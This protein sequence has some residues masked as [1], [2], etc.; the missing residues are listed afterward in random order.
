MKKPFAVKI[1]MPNGDA[2]ALKIIHKGN[3]TGLGLEISRTAWPEHRDRTEL[4]QA[5]IYIL[6]GYIDSDNLPYLYIGHGSDIEKR[7]EKHFNDTSFWD[8]VLIFVSRDDSLNR[9]H[10]TWLVWALIKQ[11]HIVNRCKLNN[12]K[13]P[14]KPRLTISEQ[15]STHEFLNEILSI[16][17]LLEV[18]AFEAPK[19]I[20]QLDISPSDLEIDDTIIIPAPV[21]GFRNYFLDSGYCCAIR[22]AGGKLNQ[23]KYI[24]AYQTAPISAITHVAEIDSIEP[25]GDGKKYRV[26]FASICK[27]DGIFKVGNRSRVDML[28][29]RYANYRILAG[30]SDMDE[31]FES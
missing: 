13:S 28:N 24:A 16:L 1:F 19:S 22:I 21:K 5:G 2:G 26:N 12:E 23:L 31:L 27:T 9:V 15:A 30:A 29:P 14:S 10:I 20:T 18:T 11:A 4:K 17:P 8:R 6:V 3:W 7:I 25:Y